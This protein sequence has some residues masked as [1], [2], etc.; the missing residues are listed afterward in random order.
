MGLWVLWVAGCCWGCGVGRVL[1]WGLGQGLGG[2]AV[3]PEAEHLLL[4]S[5]PIGRVDLPGSGLGVRARV[6]ARAR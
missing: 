4:L 3:A 6:R 1:G 2:L 5:L